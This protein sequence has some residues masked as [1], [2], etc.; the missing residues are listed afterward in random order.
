M[1]IRARELVVEMKR[2]DVG[3]TG[4]LVLSQE[5]GNEHLIARPKG[6]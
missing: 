5:S 4:S 3:D 2:K 6:D 1:E